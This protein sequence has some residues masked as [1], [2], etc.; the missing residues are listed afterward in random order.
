MKNVIRA[1]LYFN[2]LAEAFDDSD[3][4]H[5]CLKNQP[6]L[7]LVVERH[8]D[9]VS[10]THYVEHNGDQLRDPEMVFSLAAWER[11]SG[12]RFRHWVPKSTEPGG[13]GRVYRTGEIVRSGDGPSQ[14][15]YAPRRMKDALAFAR[16]W[17]RNLRE[18]GYVKRYAAGDI[19]SITHPDALAAVLAQEAVPI[20]ITHREETAADGTVIHSYDFAEDLPRQLRRMAYQQALAAL[21]RDFP[22]A[23]GK[24]P[25]ALR[26]IGYTLT[27][28]RL[29]DCTCE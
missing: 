5:L 10:V 26:G 18:Q 11:L 8:G 21:K 15:K 14:I 28:I 27:L 13:F 19:S 7:P 3:N 9:D 2:G 6:W 22:D 1:I 24:Y 12:G 25:I 20:R 4:F 23:G 29:A 16:L 17:A